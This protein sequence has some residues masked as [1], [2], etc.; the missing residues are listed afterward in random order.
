MNTLF[1]ENNDATISYHEII[2]KTII[3]FGQVFSNLYITR[4]DQHDKTK[5]QR[6][7]IPIAYAPKEKWLVRIEED[8]K[9][10]R[11][12]FS[13]MPRMSFEITSY[14]Y[15]STRKLPKTQMIKLASESLAKD[16]NVSPAMFMPVPYN[17]AISLYL[18]TKTQEDGLQVMEQI[19]PFFVPEYT[20]AINAV[21]SMNIIQNIPITI[22]SVSVE[23]TFEGDFQARRYI[24]HNLDFLLKLNLYAPIEEKD[25]ITNPHMAYFAKSIGYV[26]TTFVH[27]FDHTTLETKDS[28]LNND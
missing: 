16:D 6:I 12:L 13:A 3:A 17:L 5:N 23:D 26:T 28:N 11:Q 18:I 20:I 2:R 19:L 21:P 1:P 27:H 10:K 8:P 7:H 9:L 24:T 22:S 15:D 25:V 4:Q 14:T